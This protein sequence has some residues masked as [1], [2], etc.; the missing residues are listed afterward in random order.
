MITKKLTEIVNK[1]IKQSNEPRRTYL[2]A[3]GIGRQCFR[4]IWYDYH[5]AEKGPIE[6]SRQRTL[7]IGHRL[8]GLVLD[9]LE[10]SGLNITRPN[11]DVYDEELPKFRGHIDA[12][13]W[14]FP[15]DTTSII[16]V[17][18]AKDS[19]FRIF[20]KKGLRSWY[21]MYYSQV[22][23]YMGMSSIQSAY[24]IAINK[25][26]SELHDEYVLF[27]RVH[28]E[29]LREKAKKIIESPSTTPDRISDSPLY[30]LCRICDFRN[31]CHDTR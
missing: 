21:P 5:G 23:A 1:T 31:V 22:Q 10:A 30:F 29:A 27:D 16:E 15:I 4:S 14:D 9:C 25:D 11:V 12:I 2:G 17:K 20:E 19:S 8:E 24:I 28:Y 3:S 26:T 18:T 7:E 6:G 13:L